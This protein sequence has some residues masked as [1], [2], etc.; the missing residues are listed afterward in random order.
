MAA[1]E[2]MATR[3]IKVSTGAASQ[4]F[5]LHVVGR[6]SAPQHDIYHFVLGQSWASF[7]ALIFVFYV[8][9]N[10]VFACAYLV[11]P[12]AISNVERFEDAFYF[13]VQTLATIGY[14]AMAPAS[15][16]GH[17]VV[18][19]EAFCGIF[20]T[21]ML[22]GLTFAKF[23]R[24]TARVLFSKVAV[25]AP[26]DGVPH[27]MFRMANGRHNQVAEATLR[28]TLLVNERTKEGESMR[29]QIEIPVVRPSTTFFAL[30]WT[31]MHRIDE[32]SPFHGEAL[33]RLKAQNAEILLSLSGLDETLGQTIH[34]RYRYYANDIMQNARF[35]DVFRLHED[36]TRILDYTDFHEIVA[37]GPRGADEST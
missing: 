12:G 36:G 28:V 6:P 25:I 21:A 20:T 19:I 10:L 15:R 7:F 37:I 30:T 17:F 35:A 16:Y 4:D 2:R 34:A 32:A 26:R 24:P 3:K 5:Q 33:S 8:T 11:V 22:T 31:A 23:A 1:Q 27:L 18:V 14:G 29:R 9:L 13:S